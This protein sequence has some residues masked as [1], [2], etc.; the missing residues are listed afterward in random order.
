[1]ISLKNEDHKCEACIASNLFETLTARLRPRT[2]EKLLRLHAIGQIQNDTITKCIFSWDWQK[3][4]EL[5]VICLASAIARK[6]WLN[7]VDS[8]AAVCATLAKFHD[9]IIV[10]GV[11]VIGA[12]GCNRSKYGWPE[13]EIQGKCFFSCGLK[14]QVSTFKFCRH[15]GC[16]ASNVLKLVWLVYD[17]GRAR[18]RCDYVQSVKIRMTWWM[19][20][21][22]E[23]EKIHGNLWGV[24]RTANVNKSFKFLRVSRVHCEQSFESFT[25]Q[26][27]SRACEKKVQSGAI[28]QNQN[29]VSLKYKGNFFPSC[30]LQMQVK[31]FKFCR[32]RGCIE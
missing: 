32:S 18:N 11:R 31:V 5:F 10:T 28:G 19:T 22:S 12:I 27:A 23:T 25:T 26:L 4:M 9:S 15:Q 2:C 30:V 13:S 17:D 1:M 24:V 29:N 8:F 20:F 3:Y 21:G 7:N 6:F 16:I 14:S